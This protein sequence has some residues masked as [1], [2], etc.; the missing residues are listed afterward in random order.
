MAQMT[1]PVLYL[2]DGTS[3][4]GRWCT[5]MLDKLRGKGGWAIH[6]GRIK[7]FFGPYNT[8]A[9]VRTLCGQTGK[10]GAGRSRQEA[11]SIGVDCKR[12]LRSFNKMVT[13]EP[14]G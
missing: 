4:T 5:G 6:I 1:E 9:Y 11:S 3:W 14:N 13:E 12:C 10:M 2:P 7:H 8:A